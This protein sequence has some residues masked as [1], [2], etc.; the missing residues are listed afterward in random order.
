M[1]MA[2]ACDITV[3]AD[4]CRFGAPEVRFGSGI[5]ALVLPWIVGPKAAKELLL[6][7]DDKVTAQRAELIGLVNRVV[8]PDQLEAE[9][10]RFAEQLS[11]NEQT[12]VR[13]T[14]QAINRSYQIMG[15]PQALE[16]AL[17]FDVKIESTPNETVRE[18]P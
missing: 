2:V 3:S 18:D 11:S 8:K 13:L 6:T 10:L 14:K 17:E 5:V 7:G 4:G 15:M 16:E 9:A 12:A 1:E